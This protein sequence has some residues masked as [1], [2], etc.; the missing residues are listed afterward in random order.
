MIPLDDEFLPAEARLG[1]IQIRK[2]TSSL[3]RH[4]MQ[5]HMQLK[6]KALADS[7][8]NEFAGFIEAFES[9]RALWWTKLT[10]PLEEETSIKD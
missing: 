10:T 9:L 2:T 1:A 3:V 7:R 8:S 6:L 4:F 5:P